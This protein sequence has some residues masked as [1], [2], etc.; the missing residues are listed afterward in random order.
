MDRPTVFIS[1]SHGSPEH[2]E[3]VRGWPPAWSVTVALAVSMSTKDTAEDW[4]TWM[5]R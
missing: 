1:Y 5:T 2:V 4:S 3:R